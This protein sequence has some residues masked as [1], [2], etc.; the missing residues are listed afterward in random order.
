MHSRIISATSW[1]AI[2]LLVFF[3]PSS[4]WHHNEELFLAT[5]QL[6]RPRQ[7]RY[8]ASNGSVELGK[9]FSVDWEAVSRDGANFDDFEPSSKLLDH[10]FVTAASENHFAESVD[11]V[12]IF[13]FQIHNLFLRLGA[14]H[15][16]TGQSEKLVQCAPEAF[17]FQ[18]ASS[19]KRIATRTESP[20]PSVQSLR[21]IGCISRVQ[22]R[23]LVRRYGAICSGEH[24]GKTS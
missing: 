2:V 20:F 9:T 17:R 24:D 23:H 12:A 13:V 1:T 6:Y 11:A 3:W 4:L 5:E 21:H 15:G 10:V 14:Y 8:T 22:C 7:Y 18:A 16:T 19:S